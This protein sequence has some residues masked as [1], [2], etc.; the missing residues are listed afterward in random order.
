MYIR[1]HVH[2]HV[3]DSCYTRVQK[4]TTGNIFH[5]VR[6]RYST[7][8]CRVIEYAAFIRGRR[9]VYARFMYGGKGGLI[10]SLF[11]VTGQRAGGGVR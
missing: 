6:I 2:V 10:L 11:L 3:R 4:Q 7:G 9:V 1:A 5:G 8:R